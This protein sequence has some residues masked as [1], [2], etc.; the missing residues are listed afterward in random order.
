[1]DRGGVDRSL[2]GLIGLVPKYA[3]SQACP[4]MIEPAPMTR[5]G[6]MSVRLG[7]IQSIGFPSGPIARP[8]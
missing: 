4:I 7:M 5:I 8:L 2:E 6:E 3:N 1:M